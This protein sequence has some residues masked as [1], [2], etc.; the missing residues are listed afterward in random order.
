M[1][2]VLSFY[3]V[4]EKENCS[5]VLCVSVQWLP[6]DSSTTHH[7]NLTEFSQFYI[8]LTS[9][10]SGEVSDNSICDD[11]FV[12]IANTC[13]CKQ[14]FRNPISCCSSVI[15]SIRSWTI[16]YFCS[17]WFD[18]VGMKLLS[19]FVVSLTYVLYFIPMKQLI[20]AGSPAGFFFIMHMY[21]HICD[22]TYWNLL[23]NLI[24]FNSS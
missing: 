23:I 18:A 13:C 10:P 4:D 3:C 19:N 1:F 2:Q 14:L 12:I 6:N 9:H 17:K 8:F 22:F 5:E 16:I 15:T 20:M 21:G 7:I 11:C 24:T